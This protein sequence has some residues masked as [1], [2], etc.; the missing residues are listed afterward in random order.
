M[1][2]FDEIAAK[3]YADL[4]AGWR[5]QKLKFMSDIQASNVDKVSS[6]DEEP[7]RLC[8]YLDV[9]NNDSI[10]PDMPFMEAT[11]SD[12]EIEKFTLRDGQVL[13]TKDSES[14]D[15]IG[16]SALVRAN[17]P[18]VL[19]GYH[20]AIFTP[21]SDEL[22]SGFLAWL[23]R[24]DALNDQFK[25]S[26]N[27]VTRF[28]LGQYAMNNA[29]IAVPPLATQIRIAAFLDEKTAQIDALIAKKQALMER[30]AEKRQAIIAR[31]VTKGLNPAAS[32]KDSG[33]EW[34]GQVPAQWDVCALGQKI[35]L[36]RGVDI[37]KAERVAGDIPVVSSGGVDYFH[38]K[39]LCK[40]PGVLVGRK[41]SAGKLHY[42]ETDYWPH[43]TTLYVREFRGN[44]P[45]G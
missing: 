16:I 36:Q 4:P 21:N 39:A 7:I 31:A 3:H 19:C 33:V 28:G 23:C 44:V 8:N 18:G 13:I 9:Y 17:M 11:A 37:T 29:V 12:R 34:L 35:K 43:D 2:L 41:G 15:D 26:A 27:G 6:E 38:D 10:T 30:L 42:I 14:W 24:A 40:G 22:D 45:C 20:L 1:S 32:M 5:L 25:L